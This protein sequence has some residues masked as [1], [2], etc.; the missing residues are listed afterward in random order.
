MTE[1]Q[2]QECVR[3]V[4]A[5]W[6]IDLGAAGRETWR[7]SLVKEDSVVASEAIMRLSGRQRERPTLPDIRKMIVLVNADRRA[8]MPRTPETRSDAPP[9][10]VQVWTWARFA[11]QP[12]DRRTFPQQQ[13]HAIPEMTLAEYEQLRAEWVEAGSPAL[14][15]NGLVAAMGAA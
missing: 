14:D 5:F 10:W 7:D 3:L 1:T 11:R 6:K 13:E 15:T 8:S 12:V 4:E 2:A 9:E